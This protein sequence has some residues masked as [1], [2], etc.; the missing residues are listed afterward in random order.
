M[1]KRLKFLD[2]L[3]IYINELN[4]KLVFFSH[5][6]SFKRMWVAIKKKFSKKK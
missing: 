1:V 6:P 3:N 4:T 2:D 5:D